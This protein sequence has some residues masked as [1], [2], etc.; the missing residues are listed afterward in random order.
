MSNK[1]IKYIESF[2][3]FVSSNKNFNQ[4]N[5]H[6]SKNLTAL[7]D[8][9]GST[10]DEKIRS[11]P[12]EYPYIFSD[13]II[14]TG[15]VLK[16]KKETSYED[17][18]EWLEKNDKKTYFKFGKYL[19]DKVENRDLPAEAMSQYPSWSFFESPELVKN[20]WLIHFTTR[21]KAISRGGFSI[22]ASDPKKLGLTSKLSNRDKEKGGYNFAFLLSDFVDYYLYPSAYG[23]QPK[24]G[25]EAVLFKASG[26]RVWHNGD[27]EYQVIFYGNEA[28]D[29]VPITLGKKGYWAVWDKMGRRVLYESNDLKKV[30]DWVVKNYA[31]YRKSI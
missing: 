16:N 10:E 14:D 20:Q 29:F 8:Y 12:K 23:P 26:I 13:F 25:N 1:I 18:I 4:L 24:Y 7:R 28:K 6:L 2:K 19:Y 9:I 31:Q 5:E 15:Y 22:G 17:I 3:S 27:S 11:L 21:S 30:S